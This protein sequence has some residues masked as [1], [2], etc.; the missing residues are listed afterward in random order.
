MNTQTATPQFSRRTVLGGVGALGLV[1]T[2]A[3]TSA[4]PAH[5]SEGRPD[6]ANHPAVGLWIESDTAPRFSYDV[7]HA[8]GTSSHYNSTM[9]VGTGLGDP[10]A[11]VF[12]FGVWEPRDDR[13][14]DLTWRSGWGDVSVTSLVKISARLTVDEAG[15]TIGGQYKATLVDETGVALGSESGEMTANRMLVE[16][17]D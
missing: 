12:G 7:V 6:Y 2:M 1:S 11:A 10:N 14:I 8:D 9:A 13:T 16:P 3:L 4:S 15:T 17:L 5:A